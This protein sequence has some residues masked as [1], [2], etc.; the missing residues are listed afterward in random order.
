MQTEVISLGGSILFENNKIDVNY[1]KNLKKILLKINKKFIIVLG[2]GFISRIYM[3]ALE[4]SNVNFHD[5]C[6]IGM[7]VTRLNAVVVS[8]IFNLHYKDV[9]LSIADIKSHLKKNKIVVVGALR[10]IDNMTSDGTAAMISSHFKSGFINITNVS[11]LFSKDPNKFKNAKLIKKI[12]YKSFLDIAAKSKF[13]PGQHFVLDQKAAHII[14][15]H[16]IK[17]YIIGKKLKNLNNLLIGKR[18]I[19]TEIS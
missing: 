13:H 16:K 19:G 2:G 5:I 11:G 18:F 9:H 8:K 17:T 3:T 7:S 6:R 14:K 4:N 10:Y 15:K 1:L 12:N